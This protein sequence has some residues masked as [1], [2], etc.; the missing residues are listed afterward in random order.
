MARRFLA[1]VELTETVRTSVVSL[2]KSIHTSVVEL[3]KRFAAAEKRRNYVTPT[4]Y[5]ELIT[6]FKQLLGKK[7]KEISFTRKGIH[8]SCHIGVCMLIC[9]FSCA[10]YESGLEKLA[11]TADTVK[12]MQAELEGLK[13]NLVRA[14]KEAD[15]LMKVIAEDSVRV[16]AQQKIVAQEE[17]VAN[18][19]AM[20]A[21]K[22][23]DECEAYAHT[24]FYDIM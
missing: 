6:T 11:S 5:L 1:D 23:R 18:A 7:R 14:Q 13:P 17:A 2:C 16:E 3:S 20:D 19:K 21:K 8:S 12:S 24:L 9:L 22:I 15:D 10:G 4:S